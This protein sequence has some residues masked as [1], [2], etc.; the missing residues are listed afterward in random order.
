[1][2]QRVQLERTMTQK[3][4]ERSLEISPMTIHLWRK[5]DSDPFPCRTYPTEG[6]RHRNYFL[7]N[8]VVNWLKRNRPKLVSRMTGGQNYA[9]HGGSAGATSAL[10]ERVAS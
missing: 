2:I 7:K 8:E 6:G 4:L 10:T 5:L 9:Y 3:Q 1:M